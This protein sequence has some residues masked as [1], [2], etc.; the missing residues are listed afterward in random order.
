MDELEKVIEACDARLYDLLTLEFSWLKEAK[1]LADV[2]AQGQTHDHR[3]QD[4]LSSSK[5]E[6]QTAN[7][8]QPPSAE[9]STIPAVNDPDSDEEEDPYTTRRN[10]LM[11]QILRSWGAQARVQACKG[12]PEMKN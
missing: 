2:D 3:P 7:H 1:E 6:D 5:R 10:Q 9:L 8:S 12:I 4:G 11:A